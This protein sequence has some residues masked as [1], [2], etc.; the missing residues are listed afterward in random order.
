MLITL[1]R[2]GEVET[3]YRH[4]YNGH[5]YI[6]LSPKG[7]AQA[8]ELA[9]RLEGETF[10]A[11]YCSDLKRC[12]ETLE[13]I[14]ED[15]RLQT[16]DIVYTPQLREKSW[17][18]HEGMSFDAITEQ[19]GLE[20]EDFL[21]W[22]RAL[23]G[24]PYDAYIARIETFFTRD[25]PRTPCEKVLVVTHA[26]VIRVLMHLLQGIALEAAFSVDFPYSAYTTLNTSTWEFG[27]VQCV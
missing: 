8:K 22:I 27:A 1:V 12:R 26:G 21:Q 4:C 16:G 24:E 9:R 15:T 2:H 14:I 5:N 18:R 25:L 10:D 7:R 23:D 19:E 6:G 13:P 17:G 20:Y 3:A 11:V